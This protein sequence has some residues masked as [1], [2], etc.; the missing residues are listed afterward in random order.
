MKSNKKMTIIFFMT[1]IYGMIINPTFTVLK[2]EKEKNILLKKNKSLK[3]NNV[4]LLKKKNFLFNKKE[5]LENKKIKFKKFN[6]VGD[7]SNYVNNCILKNNLK[8]IYM[9]RLKVNRNRIIGSYNLEGKLYNFISFLNQL[10]KEK[11]I[12]LSDGNFY[13]E[14]NESS[15][16]ATINLEGYFYRK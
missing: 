8:V 15:L 10:E 14:N 1:I 2:L 12:F 4:N 3:S 5:I 7:Y 16:I 13:I 11:N 6:K 9:G